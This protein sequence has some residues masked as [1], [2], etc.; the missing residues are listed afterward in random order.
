MTAKTVFMS[1]NY[2]ITL[3]M[4]I[5]LYY[6]SVLYNYNYRTH[7]WQSLDDIASRERKYSINVAR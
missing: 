2:G 4:Y 7:I 6:S 5:Q 3:S 1:L